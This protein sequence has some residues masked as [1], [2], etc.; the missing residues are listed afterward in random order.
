M[1]WK[2]VMLVNVLGTGALAFTVS[3]K[4]VPVQTTCG[5]LL[6][7]TMLITTSVK[8]PFQASSENML[9]IALIGAN[10]LNA[11]IAFLL[12]IVA[13]ARSDQILHDLFESDEISGNVT[14]GILI[15]VNALALFFAFGVIGVTPCLNRLSKKEI[16]RLKEFNI[17]H[18]VKQ[19]QTQNSYD[20]NI[21]QT[22]HRNNIR[23]S[24]SKDLNLTHRRR[25]KTPSVKKFAIEQVE[26]FTSSQCTPGLNTNA[27]HQEIH[28]IAQ[29]CNSIPINSQDSRTSKSSRGSMGNRSSTSKAYHSGASSK[30]TYTGGSSSSK[31]PGS[32]SKTKSSSIK[33][34][35]SIIHQLFD[36]DYASPFYRRLENLRNLTRLENNTS[37]AAGGG[38]GKE[39]DLHAPPNSAHRSANNKAKGLAYTSP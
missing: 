39:D 5:L 37:S 28:A 11:S 15:I 36:G 12:S 4:F 22:L 38:G 18:A 29:V 33:R 14:G 10:L 25:I 3:P 32:S 21:H 16:K 31:K 17:Q 7:G 30:Q 23:A 1:A 6:V 19:L 34:N 13:Q 27:F 20:R 35:K 26:S 2:I 8:R 24:N 9:E